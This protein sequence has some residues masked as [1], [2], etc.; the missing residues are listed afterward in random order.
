MVRQR[1]G[2]VG[3]L[4][5]NKVEEYVH[6]HTQ[7]WPEVLEMIENCNIKNYSIFRAGLYVFSY[8]EYTGENYEKDMKQMEADLATRRW[9]RHTHPCFDIYAMGCDS[10]FFHDMESIFYFRG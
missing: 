4:K 7:V 3:K 8:Y 9:W 5:A 10:K 2:Q 1:F 6:L